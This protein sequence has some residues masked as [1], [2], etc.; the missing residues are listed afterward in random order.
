[1]IH[2][3]L[4]CI[5]VTQNSCVTN[6]FPLC[7]HYGVLFTGQSHLCF[8]SMSIKTMRH[9]LPSVVHFKFSDLSECCKKFTR[10]VNSSYFQRYLLR[11]FGL[12]KFPFILFFFFLTKLHARFT[13]TDSCSRIMPP[14]HR[15]RRSSAHN[16]DAVILHNS[17]VQQLRNLCRQR[18]IA[19]SGNR[20]TLLSRLSGSA[21]QVASL[22]ESVRANNLPV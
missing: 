4:M 11:S 18:N 15:G 3:V 1:M 12:S 10:S 20:T 6:I 9:Y 13:N 19:S 5:S 14:I 2:V 21:P 7:C 17:S 16:A 22:N 8:P